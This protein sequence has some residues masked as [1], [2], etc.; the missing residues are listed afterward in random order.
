MI[1]RNETNQGFLKNCN[2]AAFKARGEFLFF[3]NN[4]TKVTEGWLS[5]LLKLMDEDPG[6]GM[7]GS[8]LVYPD[9]RLQEA[10]GI[11]WSD[12]SGW[13]YGRLQDPSLPE[14]NYVKDVDYM[15]GAAILI[16]TNSGRNRR[17]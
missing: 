6:I 9:G 16:D 7:T 10:G 13:N 1:A 5:W 2:Q 8:K 14:F 11:I 12:A 15:S 4:D 17:L 3:L